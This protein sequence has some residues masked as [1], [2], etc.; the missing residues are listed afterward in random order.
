MEQ[1]KKK[2]QAVF[3]AALNKSHQKKFAVNN[4]V[5]VKKSEWL[6]SVVKGK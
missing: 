1:L 2:G 4:S 3:N 6:A 5:E